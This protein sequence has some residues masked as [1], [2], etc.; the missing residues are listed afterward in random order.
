MNNVINL[1]Y[2]KSSNITNLKLQ[3]AAKQT[4]PTVNNLHLIFKRDE[5]AL[6]WRL[7]QL[8]PV[9]KTTKKFSND[10]WTSLVEPQNLDDDT[11]W[12]DCS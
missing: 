8:P 4:T 1:E 6:K 11:L 2:K 9:D 7:V 3:I 5:D 10:T 12:G